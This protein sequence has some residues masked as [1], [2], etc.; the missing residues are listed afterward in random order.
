MLVLQM[1]S[2]LRGT[3]NTDCVSFVQDFTVKNECKLYTLPEFLTKL[4]TFIQNLAA[5]NIGKSNGAAVTVNMT[6]RQDQKACAIKNCINPLKR[7]GHKYCPK[8]YQ[9]RKKPDEP[10]L[11]AP[12]LEKMQDKMR[13]KQKK[14]FAKEKKKKKKKTA[15]KPQWQFVICH[16][17][18]TQL[19]RV[20]LLLRLLRH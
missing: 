11:P 3:L 7:S 9:A 16:V 15:L 8:H 13:E 20:S 19:W 4:R 1:L 12:A 17:R 18:R 5:Q 2:A 14:Q 10:D 6:V